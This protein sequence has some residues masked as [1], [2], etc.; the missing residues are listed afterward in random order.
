MR[1]RPPRSW[2]V[3]GALRRPRQERRRRLISEIRQSHLSQHCG[4]NIAAL[5]S[6]E[7]D[8]RH[9]G[10][11]SHNGQFKTVVWVWAFGR[12]LCVSLNSVR[13]ED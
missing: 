3:K 13:E 9:R 10:P 12:E 4:I 11:S 6:S 5:I 2:L 8:E 7:R 1:S